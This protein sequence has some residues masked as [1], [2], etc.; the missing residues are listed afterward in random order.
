M[1]KPYPAIILQYNT[2]LIGNLER[3]S[4]PGSLKIRF[5]YLL[6]ISSCIFHPKSLLWNAIAL[7]KLRQSSFSLHSRT[8]SL[9]PSWKSHPVS[10][11]SELSSYQETEIHELNYLKPSPNFIDGHEKYK[12]EAIL[13][14]KG[15]VKETHCF[16]VSWKG[17]PN[18]ENLWLSKKELTNT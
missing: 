2:W 3:S 14:H 15:D 5:G 9:P 10:H 16:L 18:S 11:A 7:L 6:H 13:A 12:I 8:D 1:K 4:Y 17:Y